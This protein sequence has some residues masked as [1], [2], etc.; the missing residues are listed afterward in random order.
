MLLPEF[1]MLSPY[2]DVLPKEPSPIFLADSILGKQMVTEYTVTFLESIQSIDFLFKQCIGIH[3]RFGLILHFGE[4]LAK[5]ENFPLL[6]FDSKSTEAPFQ[7]TKQPSNQYK[8]YNLTNTVGC[9]H[10]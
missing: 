5:D 2:A 7:A 3:A 1:L 6:K 4:L 9:F 8:I 10:F